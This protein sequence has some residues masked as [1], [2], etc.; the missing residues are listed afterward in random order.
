MV[1]RINCFKLSTA[2]HTT[3]YE[4]MFVR[5]VTPYLTLPV[6]VY[7]TFTRIC[8]EYNFKNNLLEQVYICISL[9]LTLLSL[10]GHINIV[11][12]GGQMGHVPRASRV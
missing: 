5:V 11:G 9:Y 12:G 4:L 8:L 3:A 10:E 6:L 2:R 1:S 7:Q